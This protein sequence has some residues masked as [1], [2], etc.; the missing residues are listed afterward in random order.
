MK[1]KGFAS[2]EEF[3]KALKNLGGIGVDFSEQMATIFGGSMN[4][5]PSAISKSLNSAIKLFDTD[6][7]TLVDIAAQKFGAT[8][9]V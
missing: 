8:G 9:N 3:E 1:E 4:E 2:K 7:N 6:F 5:L